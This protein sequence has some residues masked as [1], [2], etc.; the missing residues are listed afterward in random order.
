MYI[1]RCACNS[2]EEAS[3]GTKLACPAMAL[4]PGIKMKSPWAAEAPPETRTS[5]I[6][7]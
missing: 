5:M 1:P 7:I 3:A 4:K 2:L 6:D